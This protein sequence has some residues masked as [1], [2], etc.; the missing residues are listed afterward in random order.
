MTQPE[1]S[2]LAERQIAFLRQLPRRV[3]VI[4]RRC[5]RFMR[6]GWD[7]NGLALI[8]EDATRLARSC[9]RQ[10]LAQA[11][12]SLSTMSALL[13]ETLQRQ[14]L[15][16]PALV[17]RLQHLIDDLHD[18]V[19]SAPESRP[20]P[21]VP[22]MESPKGR[23]EI[24][25]PG[26]WRRWGDDAPAAVM[27]TIVVSTIKKPLPAPAASPVEND[28]TD[29]WSPK[30]SHFGSLSSSG[31]FYGKTEVVESPTQAPTPPAAVAIVP[32]PIGA[33]PAAAAT[34]T[35]APKK[36]LA[37]GLRIYHLSASGPVSVVLDQRLESQGVEI[38]LLEDV[39]ELKELL[40]ALP[41]DLVLVDAAYASQLETIGETIRQ[42]RTKTS[43]RIMLVAISEIDDVPLRLSARRAGVD[44]LIVGAGSVED[45][46]QRLQLLFD[47][48]QEAPYRILIVEDDRSQAMF[49]EGIL[50]NA[51]MESKVVLDAMQVMPA[52]EEFQPELILMDLHMPQ[53]SGIELTALI[54]EN[55]T[56]LHTPIVFLSGEHDADQQFD[57]IDAGGDDFLSK[58]I[59]PRHLI[60]A[61]QGRVRRHRAIG[62]RN[63]QQDSS[64]NAV[65]GLF[66]RADLIARIDLALSQPQSKGAGGVL[67]VEI[68]SLNLLRERLGLSTLEK[69]LG[70]FSQLLGEKAEGVAVARF[71]DGTYFLLDDSGDD[72]TLDNL[73]MRLR[74][75]L[76]QHDFQVQGRPFR[77]RVSVGICALRH[78]FS[79]SGSLLN[80]AERVAREARGSEQGFKRFVPTSN[81][82]ASREA[83]LAAD[84]R[85]AIGEHRFELI[86]QPVVAVAGS[87][88]SQYQVL[89]RMRDRAG[90]LLSAADIIPVAERTGAVLEIDRWVI[91]EALVLI[92]QRQA[93]GGALRLFVTQSSLTLADKEHAAWMRAAITRAR[94]PGSSLVI[95]LRMADA[96]LNTSTLRQFCDSMIGDGVQFCLSQFEAGREADALI[97]LLPLGFVKLAHKYTAG[98]VNHALRDELK[99]LIDKAHRRGLEVIGH[100]V[101]DAQAAATLWMSG[102]DFIQGNLVQRANQDLDFDFHQAVL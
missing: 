67:F 14:A 31:A 34:V 100:G 94:V 40:G 50:R 44:S 90:K 46:M 2:Q 95:E 39:D 19:P 73:A 77:L 21:A 10:G 57:A 79:D 6:D 11:Q 87:D 48:V 78:E 1:E 85:D 13:S 35:A 38:E 15:P 47:G 17:E 102:I 58:P 70:E 56:F 92:S 75:T 98:S 64:K 76:S 60:S 30:A 99:Q 9:E 80:A 33:A 51:G 101:E 22:M 93:E 41:A 59:R 65:T 71:G 36:T 89:L 62:N 88:D 32:A 26:Y 18:S 96:A 28:T 45:V 55:A 7:I 43:Q 74:N 5:H 8:H 12:A 83:K 27:S 53:A 23:S 66:H 24:P 49:A 81:S 69:V 25:P 68:E 61:V 37:H 54:R 3:D 86:H 82:D 84:I 4:D 72:A 20:E 42:T 97:E 91:S 63:K 52:L 16:E 29:P